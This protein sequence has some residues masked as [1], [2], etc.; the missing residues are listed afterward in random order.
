MKNHDTSVLKRIR[1][2]AC[3]GVLSALSVHF[4][5]ASTRE[6]TKKLESAKGQFTWHTVKFGETGAGGV[7]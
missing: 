7:M 5:P 2:I 3:Y 4:A 6:E 1:R